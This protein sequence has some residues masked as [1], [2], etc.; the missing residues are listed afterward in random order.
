[1]ITPGN[2]PKEI[3]PRIILPRVIVPRIIMG[4][5]KVLRVTRVSKYMYQKRTSPTFSVWWTVH[6]RLE[7]YFFPAGRGGCTSESMY[8]VHV[9]TCLVP[10]LI[11]FDPHSCA[12]QQRFPRPL[13]TF[14]QTDITLWPLNW[15]WPGDKNTHKHIFIQAWRSEMCSKS[16]VWQT[17]VSYPNCDGNMVRYVRKKMI[18]NSN[19]EQKSFRVDLESWDW[20]T[21]DLPSCYSERVSC[22]PGGNPNSSPFQS[23][24]LDP[25]LGGFSPH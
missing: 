12:S 15:W 13:W 11:Q 22:E 9:T 24:H 1:M 20:G 14:H 3:L 21:K 19:F 23:W 2:F 10:I 7:N 6:K 18:T 5:G 8:C 25:V 16:L 17:Q 4:H